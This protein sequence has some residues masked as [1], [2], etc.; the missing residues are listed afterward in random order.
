MRRGSIKT[1]KNF[2]AGTVDSEVT[3]VRLVISLESEKSASLL[4]KSSF[5][6]GVRQ[7]S[8]ENLSWSRKTIILENKMKNDNDKNVLHL[9]GILI[10]CG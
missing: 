2:I 6:Q 10:L 1:P 8:D 7:Y 5:K 4:L 9:D 3:R